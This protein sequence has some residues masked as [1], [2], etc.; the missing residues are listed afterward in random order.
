MKAGHGNFFSF[1]D[2]KKKLSEDGKTYFN[3]E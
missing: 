2:I 3:L 1:E